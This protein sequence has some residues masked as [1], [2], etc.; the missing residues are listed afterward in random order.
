MDTDS[1]ESFK[2]LLRVTG[3]RTGLWSC[4]GEMFCD[5]ENLGIWYLWQKHNINVVSFFLGCE[6]SHKKLNQ[7]LHE[8]DMARIE[9]GCERLC[10]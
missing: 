3:S 6:I 8:G 1:K 9:S 2:S 5:V 7:I 4:S 10:F